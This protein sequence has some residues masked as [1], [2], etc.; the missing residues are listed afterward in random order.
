M[1]LLK[2][3]NQINNFLVINFISFRIF[4]IFKNKNKINNVLVILVMIFL[5]EKK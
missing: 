4:F 5:F 2:F 1:K 3:E